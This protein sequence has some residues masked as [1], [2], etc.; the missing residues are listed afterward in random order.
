[1]SCVS[2]VNQMKLQQ[3]T[4]NAAS[5]Q[6]TARNEDLANDLQQV[7]DSAQEH[8]TRLKDKIGVS[9]NICFI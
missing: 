1:M 3:Q 9:H 4:W 7:K 2:L 8:E 5:E 6:L